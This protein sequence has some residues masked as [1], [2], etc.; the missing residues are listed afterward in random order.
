MYSINYICIDTFSNKNNILKYLKVGIMRSLKIFRIS[1]L[2]KLY[3]FE[4]NVMFST[5]R[6]ISEIQV[7]NTTLYYEY[8]ENHD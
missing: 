6:F 3:Y 5:V 8:I 1:I 7:G 2:Y 4:N